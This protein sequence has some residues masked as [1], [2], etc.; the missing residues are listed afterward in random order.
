MIMLEGW[1]IRSKPH[2]AGRQIVALHLPGDI[3]DFNALLNR[4]ADCA[5]EAAEGGGAAAVGGL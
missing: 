2:D 3:C 5:I 4:R 1:A